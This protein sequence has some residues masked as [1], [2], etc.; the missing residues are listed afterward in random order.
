M[1]R[2]TPPAAIAAQKS[3]VLG[4]GCERG[5][6]ASELVA[7]AE[8]ALSAGGF[9]S[10]DIV[11]LVSIASRRDEPGILAVAGHFSIPVHFFS[12]DEI[13]AE[14]PRLENPSELV[15]ARVGC[16]GVAEGAAL[17][18]VGGEGRLIVPKLKSAHA[19]A[20]LAIGAGGL[21]TGKGRVPDADAAV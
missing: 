13:E 14:T 6:E 19:T 8:A 3:L 1:S 11:L 15:F 21:A 12:A 20:A 9:A 7:L 10:G 5:A 4:M 17:A 2:N 18:A 16:H